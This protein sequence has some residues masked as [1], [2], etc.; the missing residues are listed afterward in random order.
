M[1]KNFLTT[2]LLVAIVGG[3]LITGGCLRKLAFPP[4]FNSKLPDTIQVYQNGYRTFFLD[5]LVNDQDDSIAH[6]K[7]TVVPG[8]LLTVIV[9]EN[10]H[11]VDIKPERNRTGVSWVSFTVVD[12]GGLSANKTCTVNIDTVVFRWLIS[13]TSA[14][15]GATVVL[16]KNRLVNYTTPPN[17]FSY[18]KW[19]VYNDTNYL[20]CSMTIDAVILTAKQRDGTTGVYFYLNDTVNHIEFNQSILVR[21]R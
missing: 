14:N 1:V 10:E 16:Y 5:S 19:L 12:P 7:W 3:I 15:K 17:G 8:P 21:I 2:T 18:L 9:K 13:D 6:L 11:L 20:S 4:K